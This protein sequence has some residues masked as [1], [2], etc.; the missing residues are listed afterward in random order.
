MAMNTKRDQKVIFKRFCSV[1]ALKDD[2]VWSL[3]PLN[4]G[5]IYSK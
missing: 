4:K 5:H 1:V 2:N 3:W